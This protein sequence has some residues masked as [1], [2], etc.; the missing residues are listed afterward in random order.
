MYWKRKC[1]TKDKQL[2]SAQDETDRRLDALRAELRKAREEKDQFEKA[3][4]IMKAQQIK[5]DGE[6]ASMRSELM[7][8]KQESSV[9]LSRLRESTRVSNASAAHACFES[10]RQH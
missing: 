2:D 1:D 3:A 7:N 8:V 9:E 4:N 5:K 6:V 10:Q